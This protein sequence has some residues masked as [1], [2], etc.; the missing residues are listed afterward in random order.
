MAKELRRRGLGIR[1]Y[2]GGMHSHDTLGE[3]WRRAGP[4]LNLTEV[5]A[6]PGLCPLRYHAKRNAQWKWAGLRT[7][8]IKLNTNTQ[9]FFSTISRLVKGFD[10][11]DSACE[12]C[13][14]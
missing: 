12:T 8:V 13:L 1:L 14:D 4:A 11:N 6:E 2:F 5:F 10:M 7:H 3:L 9:V